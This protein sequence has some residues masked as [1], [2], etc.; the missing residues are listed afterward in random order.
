[1]D[2]SE[3]LQK[4]SNWNSPDLDRVS[5]FGLQSFTAREDLAEELNII[6]VLG[7]SLK[8]LGSHRKSSMVPTI[9]G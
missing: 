7:G 3:A 8:V 1:M 4:A 6:L 9:G 2:V 5:N